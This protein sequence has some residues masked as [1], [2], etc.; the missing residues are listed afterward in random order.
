MKKTKSPTAPKPLRKSP[1]GI[2]GL[3]EITGGGF[4]SGRP[5][6][7]RG[8]AGCGK[9]LL[10]MEFLVRGAAQYDEPG[11]F[12]AFEE[13]GAELT[14]N[15]A[16]LGFD[17]AGLVAKKKLLLDYVHVG[18][19]AGSRR[20]AN[21]ISKL[22]IRLGHAIDSQCNQRSHEGRSRQGGGL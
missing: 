12:M 5:P 17:L 10:A 18:A 6:L 19:E 14:E 9:T 20:P 16:S 3:D 15:V 13:T 22:F 8:G 4:P 7:V 21:T 1:S 11:V 2:R